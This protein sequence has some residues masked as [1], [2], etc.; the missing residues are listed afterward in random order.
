MR[1]VGGPVGG[2]SGFRRRGGPLPSRP[3]REAPGRR[4]YPSPVIDTHCHLTFPDF[5]GRVPEVLASAAA[6][7]VRGAI[8]VCTSSAT[9]GE[10]LALARAHR[11][12]WCTAGVHPLYTADDPRD[13]AALAAAA[14]DPRCCAWGELGLDRHYD[15]PSLAVQHAVL[16]E[17]LALIERCDAEGLVR[18]VVVHCRKAVPELLPVLRASAIAPERFVFHC[19]TEPPEMARAVLDFGA[20]LS[21]TGVLTYKNAPEVAAS[22]ALVP[23]DR[24]MVETD[25][26]FL[27][28]QAVRGRRP[29]EPAFVVHTARALAGVK[30]VA[31]A[32]MFSLLEANARRFFALPAGESLGGVP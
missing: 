10:G 27:S 23:L 7:G 5:A 13:Y 14:R 3:S 32:E 12:V 26:P 28:P 16:A 11:G 30:G 6:A 17:Q 21:F 20:W 18:P 22:A 8:T 31:E 2:R 25:A 24:V 9:V 19:F 15:E 29:C 4:R 1:R